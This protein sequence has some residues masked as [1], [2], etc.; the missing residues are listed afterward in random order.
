LKFFFE[1][2]F[3]L[4][5]IADRGI[6]F[7]VKLGAC[8]ICLR[9]GAN[10]VNKMPIFIGKNAM[11]AD[12]HQHGLANGARTYVAQRS[13]VNRGE[14]TRTVTCDDAHRAKRDVNGL[15]KFPKFVG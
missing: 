9:S 1:T 8:S 3:A 14:H 10:K 4:R 15:H 7:G 5:A 13:A 2:V 12:S 11:R 6:E